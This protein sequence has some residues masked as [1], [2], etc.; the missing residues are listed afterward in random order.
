MAAKN[1][2]PNNAATKKGISWV[3][4]I[5]L[6]IFFF[7]VGIGLAIYKTHKE[8]ENYVIN[9]NK[10]FIAGIVW[11]VIGLI[12]LS[13]DSDSSVATCILCALLGGFMIWDGFM[14]KQLGSKFDK[15]RAV[16]S[17]ST[18]GSLDSI[19]AA[20]DVSYDQA[21][22]VIEDMIKKGAIP[23]SYIDNNERKVVSP[24]IKAAAPQVAVYVQAPI[25]NVPAAT[26]TVQTVPQTKTV[27]CPNCGANNSITVGS[28]NLCDYCGSPLS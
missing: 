27:K 15:Y 26:A 18:T 12:C 21:V 8:P 5:V 13:S 22:G 14:H 2:N 11:V 9:G 4:I 23:D 17:N 25:A 28:D 6:M 3:V 19:A 1:T 7:P 10:L 24:L 16:I 20:L